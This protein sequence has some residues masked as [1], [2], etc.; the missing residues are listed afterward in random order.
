MQRTT[1]WLRRVGPVGI[2]ALLL[3]CAAP[4]ASG[5]LY[6]LEETSGY[7]EGCFDPC[8]CPVWFNQTLR[9]T[10]LVEPA[11]AM[12]EFAVF[13]VTDV[14]LSYTQGDETIDVTG[15]GVYQRGTAQQRLELDLQRGD[16]PPQ[17]FDSGLV[18]LTGVYP[19]IDIAVAVNGFFCY[20]YVFVIVAQAKAVNAPYETWGNLKA[21]YR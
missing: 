16:L 10:F 17:H 4:A 9:G 18:P 5:V 8:M 13:D 12:D 14:N 20:D 7:E 3:F 11:A 15:S 21:T 2:A 19:V 1:S 6:Q